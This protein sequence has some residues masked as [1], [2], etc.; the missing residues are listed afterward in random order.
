MT[1]TTKRKRMAIETTPPRT[2]E[3]DAD[4][5]NTR[6]YDNSEDTDTDDNNSKDDTDDDDNNS[7]VTG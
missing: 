3:D 6:N 4:A 1:T 7:D 2:K 5:V